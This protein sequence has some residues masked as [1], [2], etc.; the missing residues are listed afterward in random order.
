[1]TGILRFSGDAPKTYR[2]HVVVVQ[3][4]SHVWLFCDPNSP[5]LS[6]RFPSQEYWGGLP[7]PSPGD[8]P[9][10]GIELHLLHWQADSLPLSH[11]GSPIG[12]LSCHNSEDVDPNASQGQGDNRLAEWSRLLLLLSRFSRVRLCNPID[13]SLSGSSVPG[14]LQAGVRNTAAPPQALWCEKHGIDC[15]EME[16]SSEGNSH[17]LAP[18]IVA[19]KEYDDRSCNF[20]KGQK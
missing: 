13:S 3:L 11:L 6:M 14:I 16:A 4:L 1:M 7:F 9:N 15:G 8:L 19:R 17:Y 18:V 2:K 10:P 12:S 20:P 5:P